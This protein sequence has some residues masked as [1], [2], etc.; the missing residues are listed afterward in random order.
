[1]RRLVM[2]ALAMS[3]ACVPACPDTYPLC[4]EVDAGTCRAWSAGCC[5]GVV[6]C[7]KGTTFADDAGNCAFV[8]V[9]SDKRVVCE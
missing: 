4:I 8:E 5:M 3:G 7:V 9:P 1:M 2:A 6:A